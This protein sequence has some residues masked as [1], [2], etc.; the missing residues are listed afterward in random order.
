MCPLEQAGLI[1]GHY[2]S[3]GMGQARTIM[4]TTDSFGQARPIIDTMGPLSQLDKLGPLWTLGVH[5]DR[6][7]GGEVVVE[8]SELDYSVS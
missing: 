7:G 4:D 5:W 6:L 1:F 2:V 3:I 8:M